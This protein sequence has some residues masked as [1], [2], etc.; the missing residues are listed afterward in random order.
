MLHFSSS[1]SPGLCWSLHSE[2]AVES[3]KAEL[4]YKAI[5]KLLCY[6]RLLLQRMGGTEFLAERRDLFIG[7]STRN[8]VLEEAQ[9]RS[10]VERQTVWS[11]AARGDSDAHSTDLLPVVRYPD[12]CLL[13]HSSSGGD[14]IEMAQSDHGVFQAFHVLANS[15]FQVS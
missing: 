14:A 7:D 10:Y 12:A 5:D 6:H 15:E 13:H 11:D 4:L 1:S 3:F 8:D 2:R 9:I